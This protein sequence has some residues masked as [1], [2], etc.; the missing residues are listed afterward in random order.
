[1]ERLEEKCLDPK[2]GSLLPDYLIG[3]ITK[4]QARRFE[5]HLGSC[6]YCAG[7]VITHSM[8]RV[9]EIMHDDYYIRLL[10]SQ[11]C[12]KDPDKFIEKLGDDPLMGY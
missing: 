1:M 10:L 2:I 7:E 8:E 5:N 9:D 11:N 4:R 3:A 12:I 6:N